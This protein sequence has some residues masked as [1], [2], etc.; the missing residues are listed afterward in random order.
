[1][2]TAV[3]V[4]RLLLLAGA[5]CLSWPAAAVPLM[6][7]RAEDLVPMAAQFRPSLNL[8]N[9]QQALWQQVE[10]RSKTLLRERKAR[11]ERLQESS[12]AALA[13]K[14]VELRDLTA[15]LDAEA[16]ATAA[17]DKQ[18]REWWLSVNDALDDG[19]RQAVAGFLGDQLLRVEGMARAGAADHPPAAEGGKGGHH[20]GGAGLGGLGGLGGPIRN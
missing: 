19:Q 4:S 17:E 16:S 9:N 2:R 5:A 1:M 13:G 6:E 8:S 12:Q 20:R 7:L 18:L 15:A 14:G 10:N 3:S 11:R